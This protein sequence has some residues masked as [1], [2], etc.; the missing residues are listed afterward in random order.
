MLFFL[1]RGMGPTV[2]PPLN[3]AAAPAD[4]YRYLHNN[5]PEKQ[6]WLLVTRQYLVA[7]GFIVI[8]GI[9]YYCYLGGPV[10]GPRPAQT[11]TFVFLS[12][13][14]PGRGASFPGMFW[15]APGV[16]L[17]PPPSNICGN[18]AF[19]NFFIRNKLVQI[20]F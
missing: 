19:L 11:K 12:H 16:L 14:F 17:S 3:P 4:P 20:L 15:A 10:G 2:S 13:S 1:N 9:C 6:S 5:N 18:Q 8:T 7:V